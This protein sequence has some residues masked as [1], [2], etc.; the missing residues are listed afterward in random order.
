[1]SQIQGDRFLCRTIQSKKQQ[2]YLALTIC[3]T[4]I[5]CLIN[6]ALRVTNDSFSHTLSQVSEAGLMGI[7]C[8]AD[9]AFVIN[10]YKI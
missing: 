7:L 2:I 6:E 3:G 1:M 4:N 10:E 5:L 9:I 8:S